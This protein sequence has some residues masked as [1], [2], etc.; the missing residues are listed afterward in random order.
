MT[1]SSS[2]GCISTIVRNNRHLV[3]PPTDHFKRLLVE[4]CL[5]HAYTVRYKL[6]DCDMMQSFITS[7]S[8]TWDT[9]PNEG[10]DGSDAATFPKENTIMTVFGGR[11]LLGRRHM[12]N[13]GPRISTHG[14]WGRG[15]RGSKV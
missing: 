9:E 4:A 8:F 1:G 11:P 14:G 2:I 12:S 10:P 6:K 7:G 15:P 13:L 5:N 3:R